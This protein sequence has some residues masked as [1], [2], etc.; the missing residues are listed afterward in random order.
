M[1]KVGA[2]PRRV[3]RSSAGPED[4][5]KVVSSAIPAT[6]GVEAGTGSVPDTPP[7]MPCAEERPGAASRDPRR[8][9]GPAARR[10][11]G[12]EGWGAETGP[13]GFDDPDSEPR[14]PM[15]RRT[16]AGRPNEAPGPRGS[17][18]FTRGGHTSGGRR[19][20]VEAGAPG[21]AR[22]H[23]PLT[24]CRRKLFPFLSGTGEVGGGTARS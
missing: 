22:P 1:T 14:D 2:R 4:T 5:A 20:G 13:E 24:S 19:A 9:S 6:R 16:P 7:P 23:F 11:G 12:G 3:R 17:T 8:G 21:A 15:D 10:P 18:P